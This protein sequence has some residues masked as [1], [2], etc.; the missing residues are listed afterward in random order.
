MKLQ[1]PYYVNNTRRYLSTQVF[2]S[3]YFGK[4]CIVKIYIY[5]KKLYPEYKDIIEYNFVN[6]VLYQTYAHTLNKTCD[7]I[8][9]EIYEHGQITGV[10]VGGQLYTSLRCRFIVMEYL[11]FIQYKDAIFNEKDCG[12]LIQ[13]K[14]KLDHLLKTKLLHHNDL[15]NRNVLLDQTHDKLAIIDFGESGMGPLQPIG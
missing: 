10:Y 2:I 7:F 5:N 4:K 6:E 11:P 12:N 14:E 1:D 8:S 15:H 9:P 13:R 3:E